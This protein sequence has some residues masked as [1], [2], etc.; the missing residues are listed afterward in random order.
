MPDALLSLSRHRWLRGAIRGLG[1]PT[2][3]PLHRGEG[4][5]G[6]APLSGVRVLTHIDEQGIRAQRIRD[7]LTGGGAS[8]QASTV[9]GTAQALLFD[10]CEI[11]EATQSSALHRFF[12][13]QLARLPANARIVLIARDPSVCETPQAAALARGCEGFMR[14]LA[15]EVGRRGSTANLI[16]LGD[17]A[18]DRL[19]GPLHYLLSARSA[20]VTGQA[21]RIDRLARAPHSA[22]AG[23]GLA[24]KLALVTGAAQGLGAAIAQRL[25]ADGARLLCVDVPA[26]AQALQALAGRCDAQPQLLDVTDADAAGRI[27]DRVRAMGGGV[28]IVVHNAGI[29]RDRTLAKMDPRHWA[30]CIAVNLEAIL[31]IDAA[32][33]DGALLRDEGRVIC[34]SS[35]AGVA[36]NVGQTN[37]ALT[38]AALIG[39]VAAQAQRLA[40][41]GIT[42]NAVAPGLIETPMMMT[43]P[44]LFREVARRMNSLSQAGVPAD[45]ADAVG[46]LAAADAH[47]V[48]GQTLRV[49]GQNL[50]GA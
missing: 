18:E 41:R 9:E 30:Q 5:A 36:G 46:F 2:P 24:G 49:C 35:I 1:L 38:K 50:I 48:S 31:R 34:L 40:A 45:I 47:G 17:G 16:Y 13:A 33:L 39:Y 14:S 29:I 25:A 3:M 19:A 8:L 28:D 23:S 12:N 7:A 6:R 43:M 22:V 4:A 10:A 11:V 26:N 15:K 21:L 32:L 37:Y 42:V 20:F 44:F 27:A